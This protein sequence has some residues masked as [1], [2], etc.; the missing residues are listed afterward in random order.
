M[1]FEQG[2]KIAAREILDFLA[3]SLGVSPAELAADL[4]R[5]I[6][7][8]RATAQPVRQDDI[9]ALTDDIQNCSVCRVVPVRVRSGRATCPACTSP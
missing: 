8:Q 7:A 2:Q 1:T 9:M 6:A 4:D 5:E 3:K